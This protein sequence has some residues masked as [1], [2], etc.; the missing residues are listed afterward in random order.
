MTEYK[1]V[2]DYKLIKINLEID[3]KWPEIDKNLLEIDK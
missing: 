3:Q 1:M 2:N